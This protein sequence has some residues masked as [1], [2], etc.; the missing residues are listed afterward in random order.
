MTLLDATPPKPPLHIWRYI[1]LGVLIILLSAG[2]YFAFRNYPEERAVTR[3]LTTLE[4]GKFQ[5]GYLLWQPSPTYSYQDFL[6]GWGLQGDYG[7][8][9]GFEILGAKS[10]GASLVIVTVRINNVDPP[11]DL[12]VDR[13]TKGLS[14]STFD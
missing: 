3:F 1:V 13:R 10:Q 9:R 2:F 11:L 8:I 6:H 14:Y 7:K 4:Q 12:V 5:E